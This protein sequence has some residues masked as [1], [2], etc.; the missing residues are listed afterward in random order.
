MIKTRSPTAVARMVRALRMLRH[1]PGW[2]RLAHRLV[3]SDPLQRFSVTNR[4]LR[5]E[6]DLESFIDRQI[7]IFGGYE[8]DCID[9]FIALIPKNRR[10]T[11]LDIGSNVGTHALAFSREF[12]RVEA[13][14][15]NP[16][17]AA[18]LEH[19]LTLNPS[20][21]VSCHKLGLGERDELLQF[22]VT[23]RANLG[24][25]TFSDAEQY[26]VP[27]VPLESFP[28]V[29]GDDYLRKIDL[30]PIDAVKIDTQGFELEVM[31]GL[32]QTLEKNRPYV[33]FEVSPPSLE[34]LNMP[35]ALHELLRFRHRLHRFATG[36]RSNLIEHRGPLICGD[37]VA[38][39][40]N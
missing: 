3:A 8:L 15:P 26:D 24:L 21:A 40:T 33:W 20:A 2:Q 4:G 27:L 10:R 23:E 31:R 11:I 35:P 14:E 38:I 16:R 28:V 37:Y 30:G 29:R 36:R 7:F 6:G 34:M 32:A 19:N 5:F 25:G 17:V 18:Q 12:T 22:Y 1:V 39:P 9:Q 13:F